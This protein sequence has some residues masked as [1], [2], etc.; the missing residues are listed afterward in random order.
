MQRLYQIIQQLTGDPARQATAARAAVPFA[1]L[2]LLRLI[3]DEL[4]AALVKSVSILEWAGGLLVLLIL[5]R[6]PS[7]SH[8]EKSNASV[9]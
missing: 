7:N 6:Q 9:S 8:T 5:L 1:I 4:P 2:R 3:P